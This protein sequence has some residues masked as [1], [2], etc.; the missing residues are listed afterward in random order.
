[1]QSMSAYGC[2]GNVG[3]GAG[4]AAEESGFEQYHAEHVRSGG[5]GG[6]R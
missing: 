4:Q 3:A 2:H 5:G 1:M 6:S